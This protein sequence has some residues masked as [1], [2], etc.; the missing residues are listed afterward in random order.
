MLPSCHIAISVCVH[1]HDA[2]YVFLSYLAFKIY[3]HWKTSIPWRVSVVALGLF[4]GIG[5]G[6]LGKTVRVRCDYVYVTCIIK[7]N[8]HHNLHRGSPSEAI[9]SELSVKLVTA[10]TAGC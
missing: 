7:C 8:L 9:P 3:L 1:F 6:L 5:L 2:G 10:M 4:T